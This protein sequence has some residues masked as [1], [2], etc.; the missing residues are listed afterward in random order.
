MVRLARGLKEHGHTVCCAFNIRSGD[1]PPG[2]GTF[3]PLYQ[4]GISVFSFPMQRIQ[5]YSGMIRFRKF[6]SENSFDIVHTHRFRALNFVC[7]ATLGM[8]TPVILG[9]KKNSFAIPPSWARIYGSSKVDAIIVNAQCIRQLFA[10]TGRVDPAKVEIIYNGVELDTFNPE[11]TGEHIRY[12]FNISSEA[13]LFGMIANFARKKSHDIFFQAALKILR[14]EPNVKFLLAGGGDYTLYQR[15]M[16]AKGFGDSFI[17]AGF[18]TDVPDIIAALDFA[19]IT[20]AK[21]EGLTGSLVEA[22]TMA[23]PVI[24]TEVAG[25]LEFVSN[26][27]TGLLVPT[28]DAAALAEAMLYLLHH[29]QEAADMG[30]N[31]YVFAKDRVDNR[32]RTQRFEE[33]YYRLLEQKGAAAH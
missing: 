31:A 12:E 21:G 7:K 17:F 23:K 16:I 30:R 3:E 13:P 1:L 27:E 2:L 8:Q 18:R 14:T 29:R 25:N 9:N 28:G 5:K 19:I 24:S 6:L 22:M 4:V 33:L 20:S 32:Q 26:R 11:V 15:E 10:Q